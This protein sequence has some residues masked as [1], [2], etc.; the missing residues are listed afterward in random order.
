MIHDSCRC[1]DQAV[2]YTIKA[3]GSD[4]V[5]TMTLQVHA[6]G[7][8]HAGSVKFTGARKR[9]SVRMCSFMV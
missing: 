1:G 6:A 8:L 4:F 9:T 3:L 2:G 7:N 5:F